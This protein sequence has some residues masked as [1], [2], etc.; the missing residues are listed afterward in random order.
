M[1]E[2]TKIE[3]EGAKAARLYRMVMDKHICPYGLKS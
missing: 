3:V 2:Q 1:N